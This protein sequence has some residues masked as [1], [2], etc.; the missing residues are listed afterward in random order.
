[1]K[2]TFLSI[3]LA[4]SLTSCDLLPNLGGDI[5]NAAGLKEA[6]RIGAATAT[7]ILGAE[8]GYLLDD[9]VKILLPTEE[10][11]ALNTLKS[12]QEFRSSLQSIQIF[13][14]TI[15]GY[16]PNLSADF[17]NILITAIN[18]A[19][20]NAASVP[21][22]LNIFKDAITGM[23]I[24]DATNILFSGNNF[25]ARDYLKDNT[26]IPLQNQFSPIIDV[27]LETVKVG[28]YTAN[29]AWALFAEQNNKLANYLNGNQIVKSLVAAIVPEAANINTVPE[30]LGGY[31]TGKAL[32]GLFLKIG[33]QEAKI[34][35]DVNSRTNKLLQ[36]VFGQLDK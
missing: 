11:T 2:Q 29:S 3:L 6:L 23:S 36:D 32:D 14:E 20:E 34:R 31:V 5:D 24:S 35:T 4:L 7:G 25:A 30:T 21:Q 16:I 28:D 27:S 26:F 15:A 12:I 17:D 18:R 13:G 10:Q 33:D 9:A 19:A 8:N 22:T 1:M